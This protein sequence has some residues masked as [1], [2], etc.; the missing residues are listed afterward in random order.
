MIELIEQVNSELPGLGIVGA[1]VGRKSEHLFEGL[2]FGSGVYVAA[3]LP[4]TR[5]AETLI[6]PGDVIHD[7]NGVPSPRSKISAA[8][9]RI[10]N[11]VSPPPC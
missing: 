11:A 3:C 6:Q 10:T 7:L 2:R 1:T 4:S 9:G 5:T 8:F